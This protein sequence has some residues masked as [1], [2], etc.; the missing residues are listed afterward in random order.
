MKT[1]GKLKLKAEKLLSHEELVGFRG[2]SGTCAVYNSNGLSSTSSF[3][4]QWGFEGSYGS[5]GLMVTKAVGVSYSEA[6]SLVASGGNWCCD[7]C[8][9][10]SWL[11]PS[12]QAHW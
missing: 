3:N 5:G 2:G 12:Q 9:S 8:G 4:A 7:S 6:M 11:S 10:A 1:L